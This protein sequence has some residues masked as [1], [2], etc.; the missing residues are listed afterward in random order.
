MAYPPVTHQRGWVGAGRRC[1]RFVDKRSLAVNSW[2]RTGAGAVE[3]LE[4]LEMLR[5]GPVEYERYRV[6][7]IGYR[8]SRRCV[9]RLS[10]SYWF[11]AP[12]HAKGIGQPTFGP[13]Y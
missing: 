10:P 8:H 6:E 7:I 9:W 13:H 2:T 3:Y 5:R 4:R 11:R 12:Q 1:G